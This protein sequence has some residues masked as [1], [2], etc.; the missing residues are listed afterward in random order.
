MKKIFLLLLGLWIST[1]PLNAHPAWGI[2]IDPQGNIYFADIGHHGRG[3]IWKLSKEGKLRVLLKDFHAHNV[4]LDR[5]GSL[6]TAHGEN[7]HTMVRI[8]P[9]DYSVDTL[10]HTLDL[11]EFFGGNCTYDRDGNIIFGIDKF[12]WRIDSSGVKQKV[13]AQKLEWNQSVFVDPSGIV[14]APDIGIGNG[15]IYKIDLEGNATLIAEDLISKLDRPRDKHNDVLLGINKKGNSIYVCENAGHQIIRILENGKTETF[16]RAENAWF[17]TGLTF[18]DTDTYILE[19][20][21]SKK[22]MMGPRITK[23]DETGKSEVLFNYDTY[24][25]ESIPAT[26]SEKPQNKK[27]WLLILFALGLLGLGMASKKF[28]LRLL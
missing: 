18:H 5:N 1:S 9:Q 6:V 20:K 24:R 22:G 4:T 23:L 17:P 28:N 7:N 12:I 8:N 14:Y 19:Y 25:E 10:Y 15:V 26:P 16:Y 27:W 11:K 2:T 3:A 21:H 13:S